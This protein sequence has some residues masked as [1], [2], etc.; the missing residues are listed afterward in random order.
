[1]NLYKVTQGDNNHPYAIKSFIAYAYTEEDALAIDPCRTDRDQWSQHMKDI[2]VE[3]LGS[4]NIKDQYQHLYSNKVVLY[5]K[6]RT[7]L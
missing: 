6:D 4:A 1:M 3:Y 5:S 2:K 7:Y